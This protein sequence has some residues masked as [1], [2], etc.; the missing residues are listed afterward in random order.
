M[1]QTIIRHHG[2]S[3]AEFARY[4]A[5]SLVAQAGDSVVAVVYMD[6]ANAGV[7]S[8]TCR[9]GGS[10]GGVGGAAM[11]PIA[12]E[13]FFDPPTNSLRFMRAFK[14]ENVSAGT[15]L[16][17]GDVVYTDRKPMIV[18][19][20]V[21]D[22]AGVAS[23]EVPLV[24]QSTGNAVSRTRTTQANDLMVFLGELQSTTTPVGTGGTSVVSATA[25]AI[26]ETWGCVLSKT[27]TSGAQTIDASVTGSASNAA[28][29]LTFVAR[30]A[31]AS[32]S[33]TGNVEIDAAAVAGSLGQPDSSV[34][35]SI[36]QDAA[37]PTGQFVGVAGNTVRTLP[38]SRNSG[39]RPVSLP[40]NSMVVLSDDAAMTRIAGAADLLLGVDGRL[41]LSDAALPAP[42]TS[43][44]AVTREADGRL[45]VERYQVAAS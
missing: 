44:I 4:T 25:Y 2:F 13:L 19:A 18:A 14:A 38:F 21:Y 22:P 30:Q 37:M 32:S 8:I 42:G 29:G 1:A 24:S 33:L 39:A 12:E 10:A 11:T 45:G 9:I 31:V 16:V 36:A 35:G 26:G 34:T 7:S 3:R 20:A 15:L 27:G 23:V 28:S 6:Q 43:I 5:V 41:A 40:G 17:E